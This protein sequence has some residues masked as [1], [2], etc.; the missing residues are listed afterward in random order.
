MSCDSCRN[1]LRHSEY[2]AG[3]HWVWP[4]RLVTTVQHQT[5]NYQLTP[6]PTPTCLKAHWPAPLAPFHTAITPTAP[7]PR[8]ILSKHAPWD[9][10]W[11]H[12]IQ[13]LRDILPHLCASV[14]LSDPWTLQKRIKSICL[15]SFQAEPSVAITTYHLEVTDK[16]MLAT[17]PR[18][19]QQEVFQ[20]RDN[21]ST[22]MGQENL[23]PSWFSIYVSYVYIQFLCKNWV[24]YLSKS[25]P[26]FV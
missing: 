1:A 14:R 2:A 9:A 7:Q 5:P 18:L 19:K 22:W 24:G 3:A 21:N 4:H 23:G 13:M 25:L 20:H 17:A 6:G 12:D 16:D 26:M 11:L 8:S 15:C 10:S